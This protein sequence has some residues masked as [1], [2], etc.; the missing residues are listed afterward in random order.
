MC[1]D[2]GDQRKS[3]EMRKTIKGQATKVRVVKCIG[4]KAD[5]M[6]DKT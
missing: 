4:E 2:F 3:T 1:V 5:E 6:C